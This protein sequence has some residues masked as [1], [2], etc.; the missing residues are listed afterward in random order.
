VE[1]HAKHLGLAALILLAAGASVPAAAEEAKQV[2]DLSKPETYKQA[3]VREATAELVAAEDGRKSL[4]VTCP[5]IQGYPGVTLRPAKGAWD[6][7]SGSY[8]V[9]R[10]RNAGAGKIRIHVRVDNAGNWRNSPWSINAGVIPPGETKE[11]QV[12]FGYSYNSE[13]FALDPSKVVRILVFLQHPKQECVFHVHEITAGGEPARPAAQATAEPVKLATEP[14]TFIDPAKADAFKQQMDRGATAEIVTGEGGGKAL[15]VTCP[16]VKG[17]PGVKLAPAEGAWDLS[18][19]THAVATVRNLS[20]GRV[21]LHMRV[22]NE[23]DWRKNPWSLG[24]GRIDAG[25]TG[26]VKIRFGYSYNG[27]AF[28]LDPSKVVRVLLYLQHPK[29]ETKF[30]ILKVEAVAEGSAQEAGGKRTDYR[31]AQPPVPKESADLGTLKKAP[32][33]PALPGKWTATFEDNFDGEILDSTKWKVAQHWGRINGAAQPHQDNMAVDRG[34]LWLTWDKKDE[35]FAYGA[36]KT[37]SYGTSEVTTYKRFHQ[38]YG[39][40]E[41]R[42]KYDVQRGCWPAWWLFPANRP[43]DKVNE[44]RWAYVKFD[45]ADAP[46][47]AKKATLHV[48]VKAAP[49]DRHWFDVYRGL[50][51]S[52]SEKTLTWKNKPKFDAAFLDHVHPA[53]AAGEWAEVDVTGFV[54]RELAGDRKA[55]FVL[56]EILQQKWEV[57]FFSSEAEEA[58]RPYLSIDGKKVPATEDATVYAAKP[59]GN[60]G[61]AATLDIADFYSYLCST[62]GGGMEIDIFEHLGLW[63]PHRTSHAVHWDGYGK[64][65]KRDGHLVEELGGLDA[66]NWTTCGLYWEEGK[67]EFYVNGTKTW[68]YANERVGSVPAWIL[69]SAQVGGWGGNYSKD[70]AERARFLDPSLPRHLYV[71]YVKVWAGRKTE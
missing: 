21:R 24:A 26:E 60:Y 2:I 23:G 6:L 49:E 55:T 7:S 37:C 69:L 40:W 47:N 28:A 50:D 18:G 42:L 65:H 66:R 43:T 48:K 58:D 64:D 44:V 4:K 57:S 29:S 13:T 39:Y 9:A 71:D 19:Y 3:L 31:A 5:A 14:K 62:K 30:E 11:I 59:D 53:P 27:P 56:A 15:R 10:V 8:L 36:A 1:R 51:D 68:T 45:L 67:L 52:W 20:D 46:R 70:P 38:K 34:V 33:M 61:D 63:G 16:G 32:D 41:C 35:P 22:D 12:R 25:K 17:Y 54:N